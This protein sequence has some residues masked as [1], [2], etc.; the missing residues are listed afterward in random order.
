VKVEEEV[1]ILWDLVEFVATGKSY[2][3]LVHMHYIEEHK[4]NQI[5]C[6]YETPNGFYTLHKV[7]VIVA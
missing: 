7:L 3:I 4:N 2:C 1:L 5:A 6:E